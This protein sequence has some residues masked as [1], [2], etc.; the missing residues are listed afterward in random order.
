MSGIPRE[1]PPPTAT[2]QHQIV[3]AFTRWR[4]SLES[5]RRSIDEATAAVGLLRATLNEMAPLW[6]GL[7][8]LEQTLTATDLAGAIDQAAA[9]AQDIVAKSASLA[10]QPVTGFEDA[11]EPEPEG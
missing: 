8:Q 6:R 1:G 7:E 5:V 11:A 3:A 10:S 2:D 4:E 9:A